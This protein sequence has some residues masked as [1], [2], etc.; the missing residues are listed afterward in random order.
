M[1]G[2]LMFTIILAIANYCVGFAISG[3]L[4]TVFKILRPTYNSVIYRIMY[5]IGAWVV[6]WVI[7][8]KISA[9]LKPMLAHAF[10]RANETID[11]IK[12]AHFE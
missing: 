4:A 11:D 5:A 10:N 3:S 12:F 6:S 9:M 2:T 8:E 1:K 7:S